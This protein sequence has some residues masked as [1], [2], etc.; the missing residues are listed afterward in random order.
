[1]VQSYLGGHPAR[2]H[3]P[4]ATQNTK[5]EARQVAPTQCA[6]PQLE[7]QYCLES[8]QWWPV[9]WS[10]LQ[11]RPDLPHCDLPWHMHQVYQGGPRPAPCCTGIPSTE[12]GRHPTTS[13][14]SG[15]TLESHQTHVALLETAPLTPGD[16]KDELRQDRKTCP[17]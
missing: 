11:A 7:E 5:L 15:T 2:R 6:P 1:M 17:T 4:H 9:A 13:R 16:N 3:L 14:W 8:I 10:D 12:I